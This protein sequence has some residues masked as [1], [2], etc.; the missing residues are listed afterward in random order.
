MGPANAPHTPRREGEER[1]RASHREI[2]ASMQPRSQLPTVLAPACKSAAA[3]AA[4]VA[5]AAA[6]MTAAA[7]AG[8]D[9]PARP[10]GGGRGTPPG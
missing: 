9:L 1:P 4:A 7:A 10:R 2:T 5:A 8:V 3:A 6:A